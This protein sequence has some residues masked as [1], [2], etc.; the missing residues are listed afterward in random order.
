MEDTKNANSLTPQQQAFVQ[1]LACGKVDEKGKKWTQDEFAK[2]KLKMHPVTVSNWKK[3]P[4]IRQALHEAAIGNIVEFVPAMLK[5]QV[6]KAI[7]KGD[8][9]AFMAVMRQSGLLMA[10]KQDHT[11]NGKD[12]PAPMLDITSLQAD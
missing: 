6:G 11:T 5:A 9:Q 2:K 12:L 3:I 10:D 1:F 4:A 8:T 7:N